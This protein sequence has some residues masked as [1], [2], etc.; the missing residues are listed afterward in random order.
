MGLALEMG[1]RKRIMVKGGHRGA[2][3]LE[4][5]GL[6]RREGDAQDPS[7]QHREKDMWK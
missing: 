1:L 3:T 5:C 7:L 4:G 6:I 2:L